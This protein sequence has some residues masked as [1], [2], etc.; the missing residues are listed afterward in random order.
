MVNIEGKLRQT[1][2]SGNEA[3]VY[4]ELIKRGSINGS[5]LAKKTGLDRSITYQ[6][7]NNL[8][9]KG[10]V[11]YII[12]EHK[13]YF[14]ATDP[15]NL[16]HPVKEQE[17]I[18]TGLISDLEG[19]KKL[20]E[21][22]QDVEVYEG[23]SGLKILFEEILSSKELCF[24][25]ATGK[26]YDLLQWGMERI[27]KDF[28]KRGIRG[29][30]IADKKVKGLRWNKLKNVNLRYINGG[31]SKNTSFGIMDEDKVGIICLEQEKP[32]VIMIKN[33]FIAYT[34]KNYFNFMWKAAKS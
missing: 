32:V 24:F 7:L 6:V 11:N 29:R 4:L 27:E 20:K 16:L 13:K 22:Q 10:F 30:G 8:V 23:K 19:I 15:S 25:G 31:D 12:K 9:E 33:P 14:S 1:G 2:L 5:G 21:T 34:L 18:V 3:K 26:S 28:V 17:E